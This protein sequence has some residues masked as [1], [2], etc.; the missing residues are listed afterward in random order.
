[1]A[2]QNAT[3][4]PQV[5]VNVYL[6]STTVTSTDLFGTGLLL[7]PLATNSLNGVRSVLYATLS[8]AIVARGAGYISATT[9]DM[10]RTVFAQSNSPAT[11][12]RVGY[13]DIVGSETYA[14]G[15]LECI[16]HNPNFYWVCPQSRTSSDLVSLAE[17]VEVCGDKAAADTAGVPFKKMV[18]F[19]QSGDSGILTGT[20]PA[21]LAD[22]VDL[23]RTNASYHP[24]STAYLDAAHSNRMSVDLSAVAPGWAFWTAAYVPAYPDG[25]IT[26]TQRLAAQSLY[27]DLMLVYGA[28]TNTVGLGRSMSG[29][30]FNDIV[31]VDYLSAAIQEAI[32]D[33]QVALATLNKKITLDASGQ[34]VIVA[35][36][37]EVLS[38]QV[39]AGMIRETDDQG[40]SAVTIVAEPITASDRTNKRLRFTC[41]VLL[42]QSVEQV[43][44]NVYSEV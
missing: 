37:R 28:N 33:R 24:T 26:E 10:V 5:E 3:F 40:D 15:L 2:N 9:L 36:I 18:C 30:Q 22:L 20:I 38:Q 7:V 29:R 42:T 19:V 12:V 6:S 17:Q 35:A 39:S 8:E 21:G 31:A 32:I 16:A 14:D 1:M 34:L 27:F 41:N 13:V 4:D 11:G 44:I 43:T 25:S 23:E